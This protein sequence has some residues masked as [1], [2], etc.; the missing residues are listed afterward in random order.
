VEAKEGLAARINRVFME[1]G[2][3]PRMW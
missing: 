1:P 2:T 3:Y